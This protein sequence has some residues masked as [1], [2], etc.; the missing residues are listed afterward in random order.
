MRKL[1]WRRRG[2]SGLEGALQ[3]AARG[4]GSQVAAE[5][6][7][8]W[9]LRM[10]PRPHSSAVAARARRRS[11]TPTGSAFGPAPGPRVAQRLGGHDEQR[12]VAHPGTSAKRV[13]ELRAGSRWQYS[14]HLPSHDARRERAKA[15]AEEF[16]KAR[17]GSS[18]PRRA[19][20]RT[21]RSDA[22]AL[23]DLGR[24]AAAPHR[25]EPARMA[26]TSQRACACSVG[27]A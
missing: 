14:C 23:A 17:G 4:G 26:V 20:V 16:Q 11:A 15:R 18:R 21:C 24:P 3:Q 2:G 19:R 13:E 6:A 8:G 1:R 7:G 10:R 12:A 9:A 5:A 27:T 25:A 22:T